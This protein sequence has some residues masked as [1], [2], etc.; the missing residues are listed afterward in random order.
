M[1]QRHAAYLE[2]SD[3]GVG[4][5]N[6]RNFGVRIERIEGFRVHFRAFKVLAL[7]RNLEFLEYDGDPPWDRT[8]SSGVKNNRFNDRHINSLKIM[9]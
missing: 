7:I 4:I 8:S 5:L 1:E 2:Q 3:S 6:G 9:K